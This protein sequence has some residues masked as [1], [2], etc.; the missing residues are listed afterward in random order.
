MT[1]NILSIDRSLLS[2]TTIKIKEPETLRDVL[3]DSNERLKAEL[4]SLLSMKVTELDENKQKRIND[5]LDHLLDDYLNTDTDRLSQNTWI[6]LRSNWKQFETWAN[7][8]K[9]PPLPATPKLYNDFIESI[10]DRVKSTTMASYKWAVSTMHKCAALP[11]PTKAEVSKRKLKAVQNHK[12]ITRQDDTK[13]AS[14]FRMRHLEV[15]QQYW[16]HSENLLQLRDVTMLTL[17]YEGLLRESELARI[18]VK[19]LYI[20]DDDNPRLYL[21][22]T[23]TD[24]SGKGSKIALCANTWE[25]VQRYLAATGHTNNELAFTRIHVKA[26][27]PL[28]QPKPLTGKAIDAIFARAHAFLKSID[29]PV[30]TQLFSGHSARTGS[31]VDLLV[32]GYSIP[33]IQRA[34]RWKTPEM[35]VR[36]GQDIL[37]NESAMA[38]MMS[39]RAKKVI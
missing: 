31:T 32:A 30:P 29:I 4:Q 1:N 24:K 36:Y 13:Q 8:Q 37:A 3:L 33:Q 15:I 6:A 20:G 39:E 38:M 10:K 17:A 14:P 28:P 7:A 16:S 9:L 2:P 25:L 11:D 35:V 18:L 34:G 12:V 5:I 23:K 27:K 22:Y 19:D 26:N 21:P